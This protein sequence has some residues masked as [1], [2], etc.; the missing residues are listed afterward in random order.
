MAAERVGVFGLLERGDEVLLVANRRHLARGEV[1]C[2]DLPGGGAQTGETLEEALVREFREE[3][4][5]RVAPVDFLFMVERMGFGGL[6]P[7]HRSLYLF[8]SV[9]PEPGAALE[10]RFAPEDPEIE[11]VAFQ[12]QASLPALCPEAYQREFLAWLESGRRRR[13]FLDRG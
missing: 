9:A 10:L 8:F 13:Y 11:R 2:W 4:G 5:L 12:P 7:R 1:L 3:T 6:D